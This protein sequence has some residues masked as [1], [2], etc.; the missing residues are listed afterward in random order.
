MNVQEAKD[1]AAK[2]SGWDDF[3]DCLTAGTR[4][5]IDE[6]VNVAIAIYAHVQTRDKK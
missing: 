3:R 4:K 5:Q 1:K 6:V 2:R